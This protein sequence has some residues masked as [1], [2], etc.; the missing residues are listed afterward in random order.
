MPVF[1]TMSTTSMVGTCRADTHSIICSFT[2]FFRVSPEGHWIPHS[3]RHCVIRWTIINGSKPFAFLREQMSYLIYNYS[4][5][6]DR[7][8][9]RKGR[10]LG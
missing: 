8:T 5:Q 2:P 9:S 10:F 4:G 7:E 3:N 6:L 1:G